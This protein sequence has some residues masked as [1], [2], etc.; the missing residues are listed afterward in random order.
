MRNTGQIGQATPAPTAPALAPSPP[1][2]GVPERDEKP[3]LNAVMADTLGDLVD[4]VAALD[5]MLAN[6]SAMRAELI[7]Q[8]RQ[9]SELSTN[10]SSLAGQPGWSAA[11]IARKVLVSELAAAL[12]LPERTTETLVADSEALMHELPATLQALREG[13]ISYRHAQRIIDHALSV[14]ADAR[15]EFETQVLPIA[16]TQTVSRLE[17]KARQVREHMHPQTITQRHTQAVGDRHVEFVPANDGMA[18]LNS[19]LPAHV[20]D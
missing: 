12:R 5:R 18:W 1:R 16:A 9:W 7:D 2:A 13:E 10:A 4:G 19:Y 17:R 14:P 8:A 20:A 6:V 15:D 3:S 11:T